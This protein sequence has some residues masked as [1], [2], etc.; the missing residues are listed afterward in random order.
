MAANTKGGRARRAA[1]AGGAVAGERGR[2]GPSGGGKKRSGAGSAKGGSAAGTKAGTATGRKSRA[3]ERKPPSETGNRTIHTAARRQAILG[4][5]LTVFAE[6]GYEAA[7]LDDVA[8]RA[9]VAKGT[10]YLYFKDKEA[11]FEALIR[12]AVAPVLEHMTQAA[13]SLDVPAAK[14]I[15]TFFTLFEKE[16]LGTERKL[17]LRLIIA[18]GPRF[19]A[20]AQFYYREVVSRGMALMRALAARAAEQGEFPT[21]AAARFPQLIVAPLLVAVIWDSL[22][23]KIDPLDA[24]GLLRAHSDVL[25]GKT[26]R[27]RS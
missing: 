25:A 19:P 1:R 18:E 4:A 10:L 27:S 7:R 11:L 6:R 9:G 5:A 21:D 13:A 17:V 26:R 23:A 24:A 8:A 20:L 22:F 2:I 15:E 12:G 14:L 16:V 3:V